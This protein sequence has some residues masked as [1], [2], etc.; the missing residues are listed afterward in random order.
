MKN[1]MRKFLNQWG[2]EHYFPEAGSDEILESLQAFAT[3]HGSRKI[4]RN[5]KKYSAFVRGREAKGWGL[6]VV[7]VGSHF[8]L[9]MGKRL[10]AVPMTGPN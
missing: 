7:K 5:V 3:R 10:K 4:Q 1:P 9:V 8:E 6:Y 2:A